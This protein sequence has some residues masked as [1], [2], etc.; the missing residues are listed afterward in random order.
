[1]QDFSTI[2]SLIKPQ[3]LTKPTVRISQ[4]VWLDIPI[5]TGVKKV[6]DDVCVNDPLWYLY[7]FDSSWKPTINSWNNLGNYPPLKLTVCSW[8]WMVGKVDRFL[9]SQPTWLLG[10]SCWCWWQGRP[11]NSW[12][13]GKVIFLRINK[14]P[15]KD[16]KSCHYGCRTNGLYTLFEDLAS[17]LG[18]SHA[19]F[20][21]CVF[22]ND[23]NLPAKVRFLVSILVKYDSL[24][25]DA[26]IPSPIF[27]I[28]LP[29]RC[30]PRKN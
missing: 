9:L 23:P 6:Q 10:G 29:L 7:E 1:M 17:F 20:L 15:G 13:E 14:T 24:H 2:N 4:S 11:K 12:S 21:F 27:H 3:T 18:P 30:I 5:T 16:K 28:I 26:D 19:G 25:R 8:K 22:Q